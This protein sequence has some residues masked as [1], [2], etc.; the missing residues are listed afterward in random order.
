MQQANFKCPITD[1]EFF[2]PQYRASSD[3]GIA[4]YKDKYGKVLINPDNNAELIPIPKDGG[5][6]TTVL[7]SKQEQYQKM[8]SHLKQR[9]KDHYQSDVKY[10]RRKRGDQLGT[11]PKQKK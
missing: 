8:Q 4:V 2:I 7:G 1:K 3:N 5:F 10:Q 9:S 6:C 11:I